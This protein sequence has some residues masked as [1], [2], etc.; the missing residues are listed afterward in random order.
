MTSIEYDEHKGRIAIGR[1]LAGTLEKGLDVRVCTSEDS[2]RFGRISELYVYDKFNRVPANNV[3]AG[4]ICAVC[5]IT[6]I[7]IGKQLLI[8]Y[9]GSHYLPSRWKNQ[10]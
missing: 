8:K 9:M 10:Q 7:Q 3:E 4:D 6:D 5:G 1:V 2:C